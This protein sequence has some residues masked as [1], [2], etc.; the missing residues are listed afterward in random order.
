MQT[1]KCTV[2]IERGRPIIFTNAETGQPGI[3]ECFTFHDG[4]NTATREY[5][6]R[7]KHAPDSVADGMLAKYQGYIDSL[8][9]DKIKIEKV[10][11]IRK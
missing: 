6:R 11:R 1:L 9:I 5:M 3:V 2:R 10:K 7:L 4:H 8:P